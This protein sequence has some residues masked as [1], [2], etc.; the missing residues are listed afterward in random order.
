MIYFILSKHKNRLDPFIINFIKEIIKPFF[1]YEIIYTDNF[2][3]DKLNNIK[4]DDIIFWNPILGNFN[5]DLVK[6]YSKSIIILEKPT[7]YVQK[8]S[9]QNNPINENM[10]IINGFYI[11]YLF[12][13]QNDIT[14]E[15]YK[16]VINRDQFVINDNNLLD[17]LKNN[18]ETIIDVEL[19]N[20]KTTSI[21]SNNI[22]IK[23][24]IHI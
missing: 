21:I 13:N 1:K 19:I 22:N 12:P 10:A 5:M 6:N 11:Y 9:N 2:I 18:T 7:I 16:L 23:N 14:N 20:I 4:T 15:D 24:Q 17:Y 8:I 3:N